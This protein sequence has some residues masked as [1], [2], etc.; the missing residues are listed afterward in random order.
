[1]I[2]WAAMDSAAV[3]VVGLAVVDSFDP[4]AL[5]IVATTVAAHRRI[6]SAV[7]FTATLATLSVG[8]GVAITSGFH[9]PL[10]LDALRTIAEF[11]PLLGLLLVAAG[12]YELLRGHRTL[13]PLPCRTLATVP[14][15]I[16]YYVVSLPFSA[17]TLTKLITATAVVT[18]FPARSPLVVI[19]AAILALP[20]L[21]AIALCGWLRPGAESITR[22]LAVASNILLIVIGLLLMTIPE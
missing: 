7:T 1:M 15:A 10:L 13:P 22:G 17:A 21:A 8:V 16:S 2:D 18:E 12:G 4:V 9:R 6:C 11:R 19:Y 20:Q 14:V 3:R 5:A